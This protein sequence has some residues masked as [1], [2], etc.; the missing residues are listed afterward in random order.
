MTIEEA[1]QTY[2]HLVY[3]TTEGDSLLWLCRRFYGSDLGYYR[4]ILEV[5][6]PRVNWLHLPVGVVIEYLPAEVVESNRLY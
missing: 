4:R 5:L 3:V 2:G 1:Y 6:N